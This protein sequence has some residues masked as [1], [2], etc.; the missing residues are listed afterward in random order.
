MTI[1]KKVAFVSVVSQVPSSDQLHQRPMSVESESDRESDSEGSQSG[2]WSSW[3][4]SQ[5]GVQCT[6]PPMLALS[7]SLCLHHFV[8][9]IRSLV[10]TDKLLTLI[11]GALHLLMHLMMTWSVT[12]PLNLSLTVSH[13]LT[14]RR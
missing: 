13:S 11:Q 10:C 9:K 12:D 6:R 3:S 2:G 1:K 7:V 14:P 8:C 4:Q 5:G